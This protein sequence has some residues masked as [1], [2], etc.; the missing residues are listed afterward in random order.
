MLYIPELYA[1][2]LAQEYRLKKI[3]AKPKVTQYINENKFTP[4][5]TFAEKENKQRITIDG[6]KYRYVAF[7]IEE[8]K[9]EKAIIFKLSQ[10]TYSDA[11]INYASKKLFEAIDSKLDP[12]AKKWRNVVY[13]L[14]NDITKRDNQLYL[15]ERRSPKSKWRK[16][17]KIS[18]DS[19]DK[20]SKQ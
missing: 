18:E 6:N 2:K 19:K 16:P 20:A 15:V 4:S 7:K 12:E 17:K 14:E 3:L 10:K 8:D 11:E 5:P 13:S 1:E 9:T